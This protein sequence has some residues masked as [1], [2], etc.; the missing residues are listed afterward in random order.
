M[1]TGIAT[2]EV[3]DMIAHIEMHR[4]RMAN[5]TGPAAACGEALRRLHELLDQERAA[6]QLHGTGTAH[7]ANIEAVTT[8]IKRIKQLAGAT[9][10]GSISGKGRPAQQPVSRSAAPRNPARNKGRRTM[11]RRGER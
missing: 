4:Q 8:E 7:P 1:S 6:L 10:P 11:G 3:I 9:N 2:D 5:E